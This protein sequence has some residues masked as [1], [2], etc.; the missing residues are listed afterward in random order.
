MVRLLPGKVVKVGRAVD[1]SIPQWCDC[2]ALYPQLR[3]RTEV[4]Q[5]HN[6]AI[7]ASYENKYLPPDFFV[8]IP[9]W[10]DCCAF[11]SAVA[12]ILLIVSIPQWCDCC[13]TG[14][15]SIVSP[16]AC[17]NPTMVRLLPV[18]G[19]AEVSLDTCF[20]PTMV[21]LLRVGSVVEG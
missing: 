10:C 16:F 4:F 17:F 7:A 20:N 2:C 9:Q 11:P 5:S 19:K 18:E 12:F 13:E 14:S 15:S 3:Y 1:V 6:G 8:S 21:R